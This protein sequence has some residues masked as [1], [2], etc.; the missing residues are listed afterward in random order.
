MWSTTCPYTWLRHPVAVA[1]PVFTQ[2]TVSCERQ[3]L[4]IIARYFR[5]EGLVQ[6]CQ[7]TPHLVPGDRAAVTEEQQQEGE[8][9]VLRRVQCLTVL[10]TTLVQIIEHTL[11][12]VIIVI[13]E[14]KESS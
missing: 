9:E 6:Y 4:P 14:C 13:F 2:K 10:L 8:Q 11:I 12:I 1:H 5:Y 3:L 7:V